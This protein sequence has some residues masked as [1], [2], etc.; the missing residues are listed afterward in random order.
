MRIVRLLSLWILSGILLLGSGRL[1]GCGTI[2][3]FPHLHCT[4]IQPLVCEQCGRTWE[5]G[6]DAAPAFNC[7]STQ[8]SLS[9]SDFTYSCGTYFR[10]DHGCV[11]DENGEYLHC[12][13][14]PQLPPGECG[15]S[16]YCL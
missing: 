2:C 1:L 13:I 10:E 12:I 3:G 8:L 4:N 7:V 9:C 6:C 16:H 11:R 15:Q 14:G 5:G